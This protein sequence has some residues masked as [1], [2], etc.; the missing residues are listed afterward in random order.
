MSASVAMMFYVLYTCPCL[1]VKMLHPKYQYYI[2]ALRCPGKVAIVAM[3]FTG[4]ALLVLSAVFSRGRNFTLNVLTYLWN[5]Q[6]ML[7]NVLFTLLEYTSYMHVNVKVLLPT[8]PFYLIHLGSY[9]CEYI[10]HH[11]LKEGVDYQTRSVN[12]VI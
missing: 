7:Q 1:D 4:L 6:A 3:V 8:E 11:L 9:Y 5:V 10:V 12:L 2:G